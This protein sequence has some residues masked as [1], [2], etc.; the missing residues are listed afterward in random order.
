MWRTWTRR[1]LVGREVENVLD[2]VIAALAP[3]AAA[4][5]SAG[6]AVAA[7]TEPS[8]AV[9]AVAMAR[10]SPPATIRLIEES[11]VFTRQKNASWLSVC[12]VRA[13][14]A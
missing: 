9:M 12:G 7:E 14:A 5:E 10:I 1:S 13:G 8:P 3:K 6:V 4:A 11:I 2:D